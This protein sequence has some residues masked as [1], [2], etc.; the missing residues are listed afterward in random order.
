MSPHAPSVFRNSYTR[1][2]RSIRLR[3]WC[4]RIQHQ[5]ARRTLPLQG[6]TR[7]AATREAA[8]WHRRILSQGWAA[9]E[10]VDAP[11]AA[12]PDARA[13]RDPAYWK[14][15]LGFRKYKGG[16][17]FSRQPT[18]SAR[19]ERE[20][21]GWHFPLGTVDPEMAARRA[22][23][24]ASSLARHGWPEVFSRHSREVTVAIFWHASPACC[25]YT[26][27]YSNPDL[28]PAN[29]APAGKK[30]V[31]ILE[32]DAALGAAL[33]ACVNRHRDFVCEHVFPTLA[34]ALKQLDP[35]LADLVLMNADLPGAWQNQARERIHLRLPNAPAYAYGCFEDSDLIFAHLTGVDAGYLLRRRK[36]AA[37]LEP[38]QDAARGAFFSPRDAAAKIRDYFQNFFA[39]SPD[40]AES[41][42]LAPLSPRE[43][44]ISA[45]LRK[46][47]AD[48]E[49]ADT[50]DISIWTVRK[51]LRSIYGKLRVH[52]RT[53]AAVK[54]ASK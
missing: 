46:G 49:I 24:I 3:G 42:L 8:E 31:A 17:V 40:S 13:Q 23:D 27:L 43:R 11:V 30:R 5:G 6:A 48:K 26:T 37:L 1:N 52:S 4:V 2:G 39:E 19:I 12:R 29:P 28:T 10:A 16:A 44:E 38:L 45:H 50:M 35:S 21:A 33:R 14:S 7:A 53:E 20:G 34:Q 51:H 25:T 32:P 18:L 54:L 41:G 9:L 15:R 22:C 47:F 36:P